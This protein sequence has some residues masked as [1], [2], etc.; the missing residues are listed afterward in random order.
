MQG[1]LML[2]LI[3]LSGDYEI[4]KIKADFHLKTIGVQQVRGAIAEV[5]ITK[6]FRIENVSGY[7]MK[8]GL[9]V[10]EN[11]LALFFNTSIETT[12]FHDSWKIPR[13]TPIFKDED[14]A[15]KS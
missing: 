5:R 3:L 12:K 10:I 8:L 14:K 9:Q 7:F 13:V 4:N 11:S 2:L 1:K 15:E 6:S